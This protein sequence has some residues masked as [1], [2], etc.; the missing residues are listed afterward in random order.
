MTS[1]SLT[2]SR[3][4]AKELTRSEFM[5]SHLDA[6]PAGTTKGTFGMMKSKKDKMMKSKPTGRPPIPSDARRRNRVL[7]CL[8]DAELE[9]L[10]AEAK[11]NT[12]AL[13]VW[14]RWRM[15]QR[16]GTTADV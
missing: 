9:G 11:K 15:L 4:M 7:V 8:T 6:L 5:H 13:S 12:V 2:F 14:L 1:S 3:S 16:T 10:R